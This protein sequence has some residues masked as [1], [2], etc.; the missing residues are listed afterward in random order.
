MFIRMLLIELRVQL[1]DL[2][3]TIQYNNK[4]II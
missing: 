1:A 4:Q 3:I 2:T